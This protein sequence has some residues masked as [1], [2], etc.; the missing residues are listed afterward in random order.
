MTRDLLYQAVTDVENAS[1]E[2]SGSEQR[3]QLNALANQLH[4]QAERDAPPAL[5]A[6]DRI[7][8]Y[9]GEIAEQADDEL[10][11]ENLETARGRIFSFLET[12]EDRGMTQ[13]GHR[14]DIE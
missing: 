6:L 11:R 9:L 7:Q 3:A 14:R 1:R 5:G 12:L 8:H 2:I 4:T 13:R 10:V